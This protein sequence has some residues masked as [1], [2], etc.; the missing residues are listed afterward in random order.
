MTGIVFDGELGL[1][2]LARLAASRNGADSDFPR[3]VLTSSIG[4]DR[5]DAVHRFFQNVILPVCR[6]RGI[7]LA[8]EGG[9]HDCV[10]GS[11]IA[12]VVDVGDGDGG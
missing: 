11:R 9:R 3:R 5:A 4:V 7:S 12:G 1:Y 6:E 8:V 2:L 10:V